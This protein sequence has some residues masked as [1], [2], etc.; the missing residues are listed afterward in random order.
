M[1]TQTEQEI[2]CEICNKISNKYNLVED[3]LCEYCDEEF[4]RDNEEVLK[5]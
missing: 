3:G 4:E 1:E 5:E 2:K